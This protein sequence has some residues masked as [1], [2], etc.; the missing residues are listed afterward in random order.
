MICRHSWFVCLSAF[1]FFAGST[2]W[3][4]PQSSDGLYHYDETGRRVD[5]SHIGQDE[6]GRYLIEFDDE[7]GH[8]AGY[9]GSV[10][11]PQLALTD[12][13]VA[14]VDQQVDVESLARDWGVTVVGRQSWDSNLVVFQGTSA[15]Q[16]LT[17]AN[18]AFESGQVAQVFTQFERQRT[19][20]QIPNDPS[21]ASQWHLR[22]TGQGGGAVGFDLR[23]EP[24][25]NFTNNTGLGTG[26]T[27]GIV[28]GRVQQ[29]HPD[30]VAN[31]RTDRSLWLAGTAD[32]HGTA[33]AGLAAGVGN[34]S[35]GISGVAP[36][37][38]F[39]GISLLDQSLTDANEALALSHHFNTMVGGQFD[40]IHIYNNSWGP[41]DDGTREAAGPLVRS[42]LA[43]AANT[44]RNGL[45]N[46]Y[47]WAGGNG[48][49]V[50]N[51][52]YDGYANSRY[53]IAVGATTNTGVRAGYS[54]RGAALMVNAMGSGGTRDVVTTT[55]GSNYTSSFGGT[56]AA[57]PMVAG[58]AA[59]MLEAN[60]NLTWRDVQH[61]FVE[62]SWRTDP[63]HA[64]WVQNGAGRFHN[65]FYGFGTVD[66][67]A[68]VAAATTWHNV[69]DAVMVT[70]FDA[71]NQLIADG[72]GNLNNP[73]FG[74]PIVRTLS[75]TDRIRL[76]HVEVVFN[77][78]GGFAGDLEVVLTSP[79]GT[80]SLLA[81]LHSHGAAYNNWTFMT[82]KNW[83]EFSDGD[84]T[85]R[86][87]DGWAADQSTWVNWRINLY[88]TAVP[89]PGSGLILVTIAIGLIIRRRR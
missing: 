62:T 75:I 49:N 61:I 80:Q 82:V 67:T 8:E 88:G 83:G 52:N 66:A 79:M 44:G 16:A 21:F 48:G 69:G 22:N 26:V 10:G 14:R 42:A 65:D 55:T 19:A 89:E 1:L 3:A 5:F 64:G 51:V 60:P 38:S 33:V 70:N 18:R 27:I 28:D 54:E 71:V 72:S 45:G 86:V 53:T 87:R 37:A 85:L 35:T 76:E 40:G 46:I 24:T 73:A 81:T 4:W 50:D 25:W 23:V 43:S 7:H 47:V 20:R 34:N 56:S 84:W 2:V 11:S 68:A 39:G 57:T 36:R 74:A 6:D 15:V 77:T 59:L 9:K 58:V 63:T 31:L 78:T 41:T 13:F 17:A 29:T 12:S 32:T 30:L